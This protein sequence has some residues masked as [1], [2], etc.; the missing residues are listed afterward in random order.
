MF[1]IVN[2]IQIVNGAKN[3]LNYAYDNQK[4]AEGKYYAILSAAT[5]S[6]ADYIGVT[7]TQC[8]D[9]ITQLMSKA[10]DN[11]QTPEPVEV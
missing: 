4:S 11:R 8:G 7:L 5:Q 2:E 9:N 10:Y 6:Q 1:Y 3:V